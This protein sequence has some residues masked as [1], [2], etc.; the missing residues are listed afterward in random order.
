MLHVVLMSLNIS[1]AFDAV[2]H[3][4]LVQRHRRSLIF[5]FG[6]LNMSMSVEGAKIETPYGAE[7]CGV[8]GGGFPLPSG[9]G[10]GEGPCPSPENF[11]SFSYTNMNC[12]AYIT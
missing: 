2:N 5:M 9:E 11:L 3:E 10:S 6:G 8:W 1:A 4:T 12:S 7:G